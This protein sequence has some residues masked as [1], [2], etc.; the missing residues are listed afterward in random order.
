MQPDGDPSDEAD[1]LSTLGPLSSDKLRPRNV[2]FVVDT[3]RRLPLT[4]LPLQQVS[5]PVQ[6]FHPFVWRGTIA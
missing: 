6:I 2:Y 5:A 1:T 3:L 4:F